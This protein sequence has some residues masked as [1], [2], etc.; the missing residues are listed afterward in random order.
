MIKQQNDYRIRL[1][2]ARKIMS[3]RSFIV[4]T[5][6]ESILAL[7]GVDPTTLGD[8]ETLVH[9]RLEIEDFIEK[10]EVLA[11]AHSAKIAQ[12]TGRDNGKVSTTRGK[13]KT[14]AKAKKGV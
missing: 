8:F 14:K 3:A 12:I 13:A 10:L 6:N 4:L 7:S 5:D 2:W 1:R 11:R 9:Q